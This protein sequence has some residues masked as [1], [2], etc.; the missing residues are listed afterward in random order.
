[1]ASGYLF[2]FIKGTEVIAGVLLLMNE[3][4]GV[5][6]VVLAPIVLNILA[7]DTLIDPAPR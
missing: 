4:S 3:L 5:A 2:P 7:V 6:L 1:M